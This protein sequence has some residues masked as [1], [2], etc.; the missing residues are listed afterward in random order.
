MKD[1]KK[2]IYVNSTPVVLLLALIAIAG[3]LWVEYSMEYVKQ[4]LYETK[5]SVSQKTLQALEYL[6]EKRMKNVE[7]ID[8]RNDPNETGIIGQKYSYITTGSGSLPVKLSTA[9]PNFGALMVE[10]LRQAGV[11]PGDRVVVG[12]TGSF[13]AMDIEMLLALEE[14]KAQVI[15]IPSVTSSSWGANHPDYTILDMITI[16][17]SAGMLHIDYTYASIGGNK[18]IG[19]SMSEK[20]VTLVLDA[21]ERNGLKVLSEGT[22]EGNIKKRL[23]IIYD[24]TGGDDPDLYVNIGGGIASTGSKANK[25]ALRSGYHKNIK[26]S[27]LPDKQGMIYEMAK[28]GV[29]VIHLANINDLMKKYKLPLNPVPL[30]ELG[31][32]KLFYAYRYNLYKVGFA[33]F[34]LLFMLGVFVYLDRK[35]RSPEESIISEEIQV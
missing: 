10:M 19:M 27:S 13:P 5:L 15:L 29:P 7:F 23:Q 11:R 12:M 33:T 14:M 31:K 34:I 26:I 4:P 24:Q 30:P 25:N 22:L 35:N 16:L 17:K 1:K 21:I 32:G 2:K 3:Y 8:N 6:K 28:R 20:G 9:N 18:D